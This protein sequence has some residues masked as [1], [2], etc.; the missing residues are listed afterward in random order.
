MPNGGASASRLYKLREAHALH[1]QWLIRLS[2]DQKHQQPLLQ[3]SPEP[4]FH[5]FQH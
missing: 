1:L 3:T 2:L 4:L 5:K